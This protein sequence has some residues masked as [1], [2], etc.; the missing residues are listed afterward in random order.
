MATKQMWVEHYRKV[1]S[2]GTMSSSLQ[3]SGT[4]IKDMTLRC[5]LA[6]EAYDA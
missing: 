1:E 4:A 6:R 2:E 3:R 5:T